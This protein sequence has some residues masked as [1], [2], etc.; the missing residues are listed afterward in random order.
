[1]H[2]HEKFDGTGYPDKLKGEQI[3]IGARIMAVA[4]SLE[5]MISLR[6]YRQSTTIAEAIKELKSKS[7]TQ[8]DPRVIKAF[9]KLIKRKTFKRLLK[10]IQNDRSK[11]SL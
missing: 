7:G 1:M 8:F 3:P 9:L 5:A 10:G 6:P 2:H 11:K 4:D